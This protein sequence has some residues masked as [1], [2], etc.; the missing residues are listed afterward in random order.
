MAKKVIVAMSGGVDSS[1]AAALLLEAGYEVVGVHMRLHDLHAQ[2]STRANA[3]GGRLNHGCCSVEDVDDARM[4]AHTL[5]IPFYVLNFEPE[6]RRYIIGNFI[7]EYRKGRTPYPCLNCN[8]YVKFDALLHRADALGADY[9]ATGHYARIHQD[10]EGRWHLGRAVDRSKDQAY[11]LYHLG[12]AELAR[13]LLPLGTLPKTEVRRLAAERGL[14]VAD[15]PDSQEICFIPDNNYRNFLNTVAPQI[16]RPGPILTSAGEQVGTHEGITGYTVGQR[17]GLGALGP[18]PHYVLR[19]DP[20]RNAVIVG[21]AHELQEHTL[22]A[23]D[24]HFITGTPP[25]APLPVTAKIRYRAPEAPAL[26]TPL[27]DGRVRV[28]FVTPQRAITPG[29]AVVFY[30]EDEVLGGGTIA[31]AGA[32]AADEAA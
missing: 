4:V 19:L 1:L 11:V 7:G 9:V 29:Q 13:V 26:V 10:A 28:D 8:R 31:S 3:A 12:Q 30:G 2:T 16:S 22:V 24:V 32:A 18:E 21:T 15:K 25:A 27:G 14:V 17:K 6:F 20:A 5:G 23:E